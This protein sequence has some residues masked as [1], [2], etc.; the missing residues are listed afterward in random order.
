[1]P[2]LKDSAVGK[3]IHLA[4]TDKIFQQ[5]SIHLELPLSEV[6]YRSCKIANVKIV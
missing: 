3:K 4:T 1:M 2:F 5:K 6:K